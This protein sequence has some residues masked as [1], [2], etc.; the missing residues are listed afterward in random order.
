VFQHCSGAMSGQHGN[1]VMRLLLIS[2]SFT[3]TVGIIDSDLHFAPDPIYPVGA[4]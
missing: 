3:R 1:L 2:Q 4:V